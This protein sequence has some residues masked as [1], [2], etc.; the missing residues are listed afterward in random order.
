MVQRTYTATMRDAP[1]FFEG[2]RPAREMLLLRQR[3]FRPFGP[4][5]HMLGVIISGLDVAATFF[6]GNRAF[7]AIGDSAKVSPGPLRSTV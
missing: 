3:D 7:Y 6:T 2:L 1:A 4:H 5:Y